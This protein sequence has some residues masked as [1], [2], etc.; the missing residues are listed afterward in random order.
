M[1]RS[2][3]VLIPVFMLIVLFGACSNPADNVT[4]AEVSDS[5]SVEAEA[6]P[7]PSEGE[8][9]ATASDGVLYEIQPSSTIS[10]VGSKVTGSHDGGFE[11]FEG[12]ILLPQDGIEGMTGKV[13]IDMNSVWSDN[14]RLTGHLKSAD[15]FEVETYPTS[16]FI[17]K[18]VTRTDEGYK[19]TGTLD[20]HGVTKSISFPAQLEKT[21]DGLNMIAEFFIKRFDFGIEYPG[22][23]DNLIR[24]EVVIKFDIKA[25]PAA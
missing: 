14:D 10:F 20:L 9:I 19:I 12:T 15:F 6:Q 23:S 3:P 7:N 17:A 11:E 13:V 4:E 25:K 21:E 8:A 16:T 22:Q 2:L 1:K 24:D 5:P 18:E